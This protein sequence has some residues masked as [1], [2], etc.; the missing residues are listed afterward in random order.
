MFYI[1]Y[2]QLYRYT[3]YGMIVCCRAFKAAE[4]TQR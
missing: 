3:F 4:P 1:R 2:L